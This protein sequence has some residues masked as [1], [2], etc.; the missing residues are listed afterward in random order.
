M[1]LRRKSRSVQVSMSKI[2]RSSMSSHESESCC[3]HVAYRS[4][5]HLILFVEPARA[6]VQ[7]GSAANCEIVQKGAK[8][9]SLFLNILE[10][11]LATARELA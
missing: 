11:A 8:D 9:K 7:L 2:H 10:V 3:I 4:Y 5:R 6:S 1:V